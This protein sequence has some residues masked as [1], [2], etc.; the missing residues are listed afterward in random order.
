MH[1]HEWGQR[2]IKEMTALQQEC[3]ADGAFIHGCVIR[4]R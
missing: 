3:S 1:A 4:S 2:V